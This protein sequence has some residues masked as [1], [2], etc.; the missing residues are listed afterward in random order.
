MI[1][2]GLDVVQEGRHAAQPRIARTAHEQQRQAD[3]HAR[4]HQQQH[5]RKARDG[6][7]RA[8][9]G[10]A[11]GGVAGVVSRRRREATGRRD[12]RRQR[13]QP[14]ITAHPRIAQPI[15]RPSTIDVVCELMASA[16]PT[17][18]RH[19]SSAAAAA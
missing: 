7:S 15:G 14:A 10:C 19:P 1:G 4:R 6:G 13:Q 2:R 8:G 3:R 9:H 16:A 11:K 17:A 18:S 12:Q 5:D